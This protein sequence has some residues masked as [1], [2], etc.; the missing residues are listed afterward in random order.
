MNHEHDLDLV[1]ALAEGRSTD[2]VRAEELVHTCDVCA[3]AYHDHVLVLE[4]IAAS[5][6]PALGD[7]ERRRLHSSIWSQIGEAAEPPAVRSTPWWYRLAPVA[8][9]VIVIAGITVALPE[10]TDD[11]VDDLGGDAFVPSSERL[12]DEQQADSAMADTTAAESAE[13]TFTADGGGEGESEATIA[14]ES[15]VDS[16]AAGD[17]DAPRIDI[18]SDQLDRATAQFARR[19]G[20]RDE[21]MELPVDVG[22]CLQGEPDLDGPFLAYERG[23]VDGLEA[24]FVAQGSP[25]AVDRVIVFRSG[26]CEVLATHL[27]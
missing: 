2:P 23:L 26:T 17:T 19:S 20:G 5:P 16:T 1:A 18:T 15:A 7:L 24:V 25:G 10:A 11:A 8:A 13:D 21:A 14:A 12:S 9:A 27:P 6:S 4:A 22:A 3:E